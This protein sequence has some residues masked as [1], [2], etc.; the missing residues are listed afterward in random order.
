MAK[1]KL[2]TVTLSY[3]HLNPDQQGVWDYRVEKVGNSTDLVP[4]Q[5]LRKA[6]VETL[7]VAHNWTVIV[8]PHKELS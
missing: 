4:Y 8:I 3:P 1:K 5:M 2:M 6:E 7:C